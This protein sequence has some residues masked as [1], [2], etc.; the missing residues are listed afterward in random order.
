MKKLN[1]LLTFFVGL[2]ILSCSSDDDSTTSTQEV[3]LDRFEQKLY[4]NEGLNQIYIFDYTNNR[5]ETSSYYN[6]Q[7][8]LIGYSNW[9]YNSNG[10]LSEINDFSSDNVLTRNL[11]IIY[12][13]QN[14]IINTD[15]VYSSS[16]TNHILVNFTH[17]SDNTISSEYSVSGNIEN[18][19]FEMN[20]EGLIDKEIQ[21]GIT[22]VS[23][24]YDGNNPISKTSYSTTHTYSYHETG[25]YPSD[26]ENFL[27]NSTNPINYVLFAN[28]LNDA[29]DNLTRKLITKISSSIFTE[30]NVYDLNENNIPLYLKR[31]Q[32]G[33]LDSE[34][35]YFYE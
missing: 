19:T 8:V 3:Q 28:S 18:K 31:Y 10:L 30:E 5:P 4:D 34:I 15:M 24:L 22:I 27:G 16:P 7:N 1:L 29:S 14:R 6:A 21:N 25:V 33:E 35:E 23:V 9:E 26:I 2:T 12:D 17:N 13:N 32:N 11:K 20:S